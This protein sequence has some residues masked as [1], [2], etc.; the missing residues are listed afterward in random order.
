MH[1]HL[2]THWFGES[3]LILHVTGSRHKG[4]L[5]L[6]NKTTNNE[7][8][9]FLELPSMRVVY[10]NQAWLL[11]L[12]HIATFAFKS[13]LTPSARYI[14]TKD[15]RHYADH[16]CEIYAKVQGEFFQ[17][18]YFPSCDARRTFVS[19]SYVSS[20]VSIMYSKILLSRLCRFVIMFTLRLLRKK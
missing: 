4:E 11:T 19:S 3:I 8:N 17:N 14:C 5:L 6:S 20:D 10:F 9:S 18:I 13:A 15:T 12:F 1:R 16:V 2:Y 7:S